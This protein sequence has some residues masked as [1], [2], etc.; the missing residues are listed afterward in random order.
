MLPGH[1]AQ[2]ALTPSFSATIADANLN[3]W[4]AHSPVNASRTASRRPAHEL[5]AD[6]DRYSFIVM[7][8]HHQ[9][10]AGLPAHP[11]PAVRLTTIG[12]FK[13]TRFGP[14][15]GPLRGWSTVGLPTLSNR[16]RLARIGDGLVPGEP[17]SQSAG[18]PATARSKL[19]LPSPRVPVNGH[20]SFLRSGRLKFSGLAAAFWVSDQP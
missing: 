12:Q 9:L 8:L 11:I 2:R 1:C 20:R 7:D 15:L 10:L 13:S 14:S 6:V 4:P 17:T 5:G 16:R 3:G 19:S 18:Y